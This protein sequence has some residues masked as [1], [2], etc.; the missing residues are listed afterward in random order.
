VGD[1]KSTI[2]QLIDTE[3][4]SPWR[5]AIN[6]SVVIDDDLLNNLKKLILH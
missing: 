1:G 2:K 4:K 3:N 5:R 6:S